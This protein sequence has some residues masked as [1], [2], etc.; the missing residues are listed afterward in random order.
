MNRVV[1]YSAGLVLAFALT[2]T[3]FSLVLAHVHHAPSALSSPALIA[4]VLVLAMVQLAAQLYFF[5]HLGQDK[6]SRWNTTLFVFTFFGILVV[7]L[8][9]VWIMGHLNYNMTPAQMNQYF[10][11]QSTF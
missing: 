4:I 8:A 2:L 3:A 1:S 9:S 7:V 6:E 11:D 5:L 10:Q